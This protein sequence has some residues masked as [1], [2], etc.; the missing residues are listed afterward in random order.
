MN[1]KLDPNCTCPCQSEFRIEKD[2]FGELKVPSDKYY[3]AQTLRSVMNF[4]IG[5]EFERMPVSAY[6]K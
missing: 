3:G 5:G 1:S 6:N 2:T 4:P